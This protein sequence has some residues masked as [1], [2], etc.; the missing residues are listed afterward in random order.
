MQGLHV[1]TTLSFIVIICRRMFGSIDKLISDILM[2]LHP[3]LACKHETPL[4]IQ[5]PSSEKSES[6][7]DGLQFD[8]ENSTE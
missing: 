5:P 3:G 4:T 1:G 7:H 2:S 6:N 8:D